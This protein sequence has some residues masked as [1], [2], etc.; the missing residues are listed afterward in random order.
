MISEKFRNDD[1]PYL[2]I[3]DAKDTEYTVNGRKN[4]TGKDVRTAISETI[5]YTQ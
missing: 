4:K 5:H 3:N 2:L 1:R